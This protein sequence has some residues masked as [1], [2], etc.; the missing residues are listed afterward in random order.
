MAEVPSI[1][2]LEK[3]FDQ[4][5]AQV[6]GLFARREKLQAEIDQ[7]D[8]EMGSLANVGGRPSRRHRG[9]HRLKNKTPLRPV[10]LQVLGKN[11]KG[12]SL[13]DLVDKILETEYRSNSA[14]FRNVVY[15]CLYNT[16]EIE[17]DV[18]KGVYKLTK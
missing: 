6:L 15:Q 1:A 16:P 2:D 9:K 12:L 17:H 18:A 10:V 3:Q 4:R 11:K 7:L 13:N 5:K 14:N 8:A